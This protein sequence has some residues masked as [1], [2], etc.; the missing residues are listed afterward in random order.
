M[1]LDRWLGIPGPVDPF[2]GKTASAWTQDDLNT[3][4]ACIAT[5]RRYEQFKIPLT[6]ECGQKTE[7]TIR[8]PGL[9]QAADFLQ[10]VRDQVGVGATPWFE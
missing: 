3:W 5:L 1:D 6:C 10:R 7:K 2:G 4:E 8:L 9:R